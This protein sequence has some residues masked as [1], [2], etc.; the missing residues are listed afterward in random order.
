MTRPQLA[1]LYSPAFCRNAMCKSRGAWSLCSSQPPILLLL[2][3][4]DTNGLW[5]SV[6]AIRYD[7]N[8]PCRSRELRIRCLLSRAAGRGGWWPEDLI[9]RCFRELLIRSR[10]SSVDGSTGMKQCIRAGET[11][12]RFR[13]SM[14]VN[15]CAIKQL[16]GRKRTESN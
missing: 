16:Y 2:L 15:R 11:V 1:R 4:V 13:G 3:M 8:G 9:R 10:L 12:C 7:G 14:C 5:L 6:K